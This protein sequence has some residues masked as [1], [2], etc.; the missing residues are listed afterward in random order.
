MNH[1]G[2]FGV[3]EDLA[4]DFRGLQKHGI[5][6]DIPTNAPLDDTHNRVTEIKVASVDDGSKAWKYEVSRDGSN[7]RIKIGDPDKLIT[8]VQR[9]RITYRVIGGL[10]PQDTADE[11]YWNATVP[12]L[13]RLASAALLAST[14]TIYAGRRCFQGVMTGFQAPY[15][16]L[17]WR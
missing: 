8:G 12:R 5:Y 11:L 9:Y 13:A 6:R 14:R 2:T 17:V 16:S 10:N 7:L 4:V 3:V 1:D 15:A